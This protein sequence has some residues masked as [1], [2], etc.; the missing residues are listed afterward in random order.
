ML[1]ANRFTVLPTRECRNRLEEALSNRRPIARGES[2]RAAVIAIQSALADLNHNYLLAAEIDGYFGQRTYSAVESFQRDYGLAADGMVGHQTMSQLDMLYSG[3]VVRKPRGL[4][5]HVGVDYL[6]P[7]HYGDAFSL[8]SCVNDARKMQEL[9]TAIGYDTMLLENEAATVASFTGFMRSA[10]ND[11]CD[12]DSLLVTF[13]GHGAQIPNLSA[14][15]ESDSKDETLCFY[16]RM[17]VDDEFYALL[18]QFREGVRVHGIF[19]SCHSGT[20]VKDLDQVNQEIEEYRADILARL[21]ESDESGAAS[22]KSVE[23]E[24]VMVAT[25]SLAGGGRAT[26]DRTTESAKAPGSSNR[27]KVDEA[28]AALFVDLYA[29]EIATAANKKQIDEADWRR[30]YDTNKSMYDAIINVVGPAE[31]QQI[32]CS[33]V[34]LSACADAQTTPSGRVYSL[35]T[36]NLIAAWREGKYDGS[37]RQFHD[38][39]RN[40]ARADATPQLNTFGNRLAEARLYDRPFVI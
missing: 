19:D 27:Q 25:R 9:A 8:D 40:I 18:A 36:Y 26:K 1:T 17:L 10:I 29:D 23:V 5:I 32:S 12:G 13:S 31:H 7:G 21:R 20:V 22:V 11:L 38:K 16:D 3:E 2:N 33:M 39:L 4:S 34:S 14:D 30:I 6:D 37:Y 15:P 24:S 35:F 28:I